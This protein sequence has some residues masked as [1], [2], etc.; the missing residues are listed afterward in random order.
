MPYKSVGIY[1]THDPRICNFNAK[2]FRAN[3]IKKL[4][5]Y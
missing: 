5:D 3:L 2:L 1:Y 4:S